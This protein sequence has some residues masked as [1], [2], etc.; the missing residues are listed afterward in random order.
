MTTRVPQRNL[1][2]VPSFAGL[3]LSH[4]RLPGTQMPAFPVLPLRGC[5]FQGLNRL[6]NGAS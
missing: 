6:R 1:F 2:C 5:R 3:D 4:F